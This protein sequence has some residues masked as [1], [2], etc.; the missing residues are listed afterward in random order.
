MRNNKLALLS[1]LLIILIIRLNGHTQTDTLK[2]FFQGDFLK[3]ESFKIYYQNKLIQE[4]TCKK[5]DIFQ[6]NIPIDSNWEEGQLLDLKVFRKGR[7]QLA[8]RDTYFATPYEPS[9]RYLIIFRS[10]KLKK[11]YSVFPIWRDE[12]FYSL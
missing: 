5:Y 12:R 11:R 6:F 10:Q 8:Y 4:I 7:F 2:I 3:M 1:L 9:N